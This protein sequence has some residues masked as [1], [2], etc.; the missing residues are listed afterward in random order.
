MLLNVYSVYDIKAEAYLPPFFLRTDAEAIRS[1]TS[2]SLDENH[3]FCKHSDDYALFRLGSFDDDDGE[4]VAETIPFKL[5]TASA[6]KR[7][8]AQD[9][10]DN[11][12]S[13]KKD[14]SK[15]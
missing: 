11:V 10:V 12:A 3:P 13:L 8:V 5:T 4:L 7:S 9:Y 6:V 2:A 15:A 1:F 14:A